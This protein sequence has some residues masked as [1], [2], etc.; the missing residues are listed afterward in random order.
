MK[1]ASVSFVV[2]A[3]SISNQVMAFSSPD[4]VKTPGVLC[5]TNDP[6]FQSFDY[7][8]HIARCARNVGTNEKKQIA[9]EYGNIPKTDWPNYEFDHLIPLCAGGSDNVKNLWPQ[10]LAEAHQKDV[11][12]NSIC[13]GMKAGTMTQAQAVQKVHDW[14]ASLAEAPNVQ[15]LAPALEATNVSCTAQDSITLHFLVSGPRQISNV[16]VN[17]IDRDGEHEALHMTKTVN[18]KNIKAKSN[19]LRSLLRFVVNEKSE[20]HFELFLP[21][22]LNS[23][24]LFNGYLKIGFEDNYPT[25][26][27]IKCEV[28]K[29]ALPGN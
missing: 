7:P 11:L 26:H 25:L 14:F 16:F 5:S 20:D 2:L 29:T 6:N 15:V 24:S 21:A 19:L 13:L 3:L 17:V 18:A 4:P 8:E 10:P 1:R 27:S 9:A 22:D 12:E 23:Q 28:D